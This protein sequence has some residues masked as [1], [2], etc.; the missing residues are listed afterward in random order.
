GEMGRLVT[1]VV[2]GRPSDRRL[3]SAVLLASIPAG[4]AGFAFQHAIETRLRS[5]TVVAAST[6]LWALVLWWADRRAARA[7]S[8]H[9]LREVGTGRAFL[10]GLAQALALVPGT[11]RSG[12]TISA[13]LFAGLDRSTAARFAFLLGLPVTVAA[14]L[15]ETVSQARAGLAGDDLG[16]LVLGVGTSFAAGLAAIRFLVAYLRRRT[17]LVFVTY[18]LVLGV[19]LLW[20]DR[21]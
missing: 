16:A 21:S 13:G 17:L 14:G 15:L 3:A 7:A 1:G 18:R 10:V 4:L 8:V 2:A 20:L 19:L 9:D 12:I 6:I 5:T 11:S